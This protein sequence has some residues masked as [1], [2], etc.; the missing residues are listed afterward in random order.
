MIDDSNPNQSRRASADSVVRAYVADGGELSQEAID[1]LAGKHPDLA[2]ELRR[3]VEVA[4][5]T[6]RAQQRAAQVPS[7]HSS[8]SNIS[9]LSELLLDEPGWELAVYTIGE[10]IGGGKFGEVYEAVSTETGQRVAIKCLRREYRA[11]PQALERFRMEAEALSRLDHPGIVRVLDVRTEDAIPCIVMERIAGHDLHR[12]T[13]SSPLDPSRAASIIAEAADAC[14]AAHER[15]ILHRDIKPENIL[16]DE[17]GH[18]RLTD[19]GLAKLLDRDVELT[20][21]EQALG[22]PHYMPPEQYD[23]RLG[24]TT[25]LADVYALGGTLYYLLTGRPPFPIGDGVGREAT[26]HQIGWAR[27]RSPAAANNQV[28]A[29]LALICLM[30]LEKRP[31]DRYADA[32]ALAEDLRRFL[33]GKPIR[34]RLP[35]PAGRSWRWCARRPVMAAM[36]AVLLLSLTAGSI[37]AVHFAQEADTQRGLTEEAR[38]AEADATSQRVFREH[39]AD[40]RDAQLALDSGRTDEAVRILKKYE[41]PAPDL[42]PR[43]F[44]WA[45]LSRL[46]SAPSAIECVSEGTA[47]SQIRISPANDFLACIDTAGSL[48]V[49]DPNGCTVLFSLAGPFVEARFTPDGT[50]LVLTTAGHSSRV[51]LVKTEDGTVARE[52]DLGLSTTAMS[53][54]PDG[55]SCFVGGAANELLLVNFSSERVID[56]AAGLRDALRTGSDIQHGV[57]MSTAYSRDGKRVAV[58]YENGVTQVWSLGNKRVVARGPVHTGPVMGLSFDANGTRV[59][60]QSFGRYDNRSL[61]E[62]PGEMLVWNA[63]DGS[64]IAFARPHAAMPQYAPISYSA[65]TFGRH[66]GQMQPEFHPELDRVVTTGDREVVVWDAATGQRAGSYSGHGAA[67]IAADVSP[68]GQLVAGVEQ[69]GAVHVWPFKTDGPSCTI[70]EAAAGIRALQ[71]DG[72]RLVLL[73]EYGIERTDG[74]RGTHFSRSER[75]VIS[76]LS[77]ASGEI[78]DIADGHNGAESLAVT[79]YGV[80]HDGVVHAA[81]SE[82]PTIKLPGAMP[83]LWRDVVIASTADGKLLAI[84]RQDGTVQ[85]VDPGSGQELWSA[86]LHDG[87]VTSLAFSASGVRLASGGQDRRVRVMGSSDG[88]VKTELRGHTREVSGVAFSPDGSRLASSSGLLGSGDMSPGEVHVW[89]LATEQLSLQLRAAPDEVYCGVAW[90]S[91]GLRLFAA[92]NPQSDADG[93]VEPGRIVEW[94]AVE[95]ERSP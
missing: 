85:V 22:T 23:R 6:M 36:L 43:G 48:A 60:S 72:E 83:E 29:D 14:H 82:P 89:H 73:R 54:S 77:I 70:Y 57:V 8:D 61:S 52:I 1:I 47:W 21:E 20:G 63:E 45:F 74:L 15:G 71:R 46:A 44:E 12:A 2:D 86:A 37:A 38:T 84:G 94:S 13:R 51:L 24:P 42:D 58:G 4:Q 88:S 9:S 26:L 87:P 11:H 10:R 59:A 92:A 78:V 93:R 64:R 31:H 55:Q 35:G 68:D 41:N 16:L 32:K 90:S 56:L 81:R 3:A 75:R 25:H 28:P 50:S 34:A 69:S 65:A 5:L 79:P 33:S 40:M 53:V 18:P 27:P 62:V 66:Y 49:L 39:F 95:T 17:S 76:S 67:M 7:E 80:V 91:D 30:C 19:F